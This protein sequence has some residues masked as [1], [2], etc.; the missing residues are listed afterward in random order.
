M[1]YVYVRIELDPTR[2]GHG[3]VRWSEC[4]TLDAGEHVLVREASDG[5]CRYLIVDEYAG[6]TYLANRSDG[7]MP[8][9]YG[10]YNYAVQVLA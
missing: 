7:C 1:N 8:G 4:P 5:E 2:P 3:T 10:T 9:T 6:M